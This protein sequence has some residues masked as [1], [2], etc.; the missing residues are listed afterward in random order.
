MTAQRPFERVSRQKLDSVQSEPSTAH[1]VLGRCHGA[2][3]C[4]QLWCGPE[5]ARD[6][7]MHLESADNPTAGFPRP[8][9]QRDPK[10]PSRFVAV[11]ELCR[12]CHRTSWRSISDAMQVGFAELRL[13]RPGREL[14]G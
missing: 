4:W 10:S 3:G 7:I 2:S 14:F 11:P 5:C 1:S 9:G 12:R 6:S 8:Y 13:S